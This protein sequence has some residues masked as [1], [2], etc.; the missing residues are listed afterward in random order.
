VAD[1]VRIE[2]RNLHN[3][4]PEVSYSKP[5]LI[6][7]SAQPVPDA[8][9]PDPAAGGTNESRTAAS[10]VLTPACPVTQLGS[11]ELV[12]SSAGPLTYI[13]HNEHEHNYCRGCCVLRVEPASGPLRREN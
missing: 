6:S 11:P 8:A 9:D 2:A 13:E 3:L 1:E 10:S 4:T 12:D 7:R 5:T